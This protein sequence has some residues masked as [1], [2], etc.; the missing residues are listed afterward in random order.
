MGHSTK[1]LSSLIVSV[2][3]NNNFAT[4]VARSPIS[5]IHYP[6]NVS[7]SRNECS[8][9]KQYFPE[10]PHQ[11][12]LHH[13]LPTQHLPKPKLK[14]LL[15]TEPLQSNSEQKRPILQLLIP[16]SRTHTQRLQQPLLQILHLT[17]LDMSNLHQTPH[18][19]PLNMPN[20]PIGKIPAPTPLIPLNNPTP[21]SSPQP[22]KYH[23]AKNRAAAVSIIAQRTA[24]ST[25]KQQIPPQ[26]SQQP[27]LVSPRPLSNP[28]HT[29]TYVDPNIQALFEQQNRILAQNSSLITA[30]TTTVSSLQSEASTRTTVAHETLAKQTDART[31]KGL[32]LT[33]FPKF[34][35]E[36]QDDIIKWYS[37]ILTTNSIVPSTN[38]SNS[39]ISE[40]FYRS[41]RLAFKKNAATIID[42]HTVTLHGRGVEFF[43]TA[44]T[45]FNP[46]CPKSDHSK[47]SFPSTNS[48]A[49]RRC[50]RMNFL[51]SSSV[52]NPNSNT[53]P[54]FSLRS[55]FPVNSSTG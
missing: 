5:L 41:L 23:I 52:G 9:W 39:P 35:N 54:Y 51:T 43:L 22:K 2:P 38:D 21:L 6:M 15:Q 8:G 25:T 27:F 14:R 3:W 36:S 18:L 13:L 30:L 16:P 1:Q 37:D 50:R 19:T 45:I 55:K 24:A 47:N 48:S 20:H 53:T 11:L 40:L 17:A 28:N 33:N 12:H 44:L 26:S 31:I 4:N 42:A 49:L 32:S 7:P 29:Q 46:K 10:C 34:S